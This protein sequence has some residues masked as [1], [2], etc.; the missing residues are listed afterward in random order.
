MPEET[1]GARHWFLL[2]LSLSALLNRRCQGAE[3]GDGFRVWFAKEN[4]G[5]GVGLL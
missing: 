5:L 4:A 2:P 3:V 1:R